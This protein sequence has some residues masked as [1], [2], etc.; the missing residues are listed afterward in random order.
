MTAYCEA[1]DILL[2]VLG[3][4]EKV[5][6]TREEA[7]A[8]LERYG[9]NE[10]AGRKPPS[11]F[12]RVLAQ[13][14][15]PMIL[16][17]LG[18][19]GLSLWAG[20]G[21]DWLD[22]AIILFI[23]VVNAAISI[24]Q[25]DHAQKALDELKRMAAPTALVRRA[26]ELCRVEA[27][28]LVPG[29]VVYLEAGDQVSADGRLL[30]ASGL[31][32]DESAMTGESVSVDKEPREGLSPDTPLAERRNMVLSGT[33]VTAGKGTYVVTATGMDTEMGRIAGLLTEAGG[34]ETPLQRRMGEI[35]KALSFLCLCVCAVMFGIGLLQGR[36]LMEMFL[37]AVSLAVAAIPEGLSAVV[38]IVLALGVQR[39]ARRGAIITKLAAV[40]TLGCAQVICSDKTGT[41]TRNRMEVTRL[42]SVSPAGQ[43]PALTAFAL[44][45]DAQL[46]P[47]GYLGDP[48]EGAL[49]VKAKEAGLSQRTLEETLPR[50]AE[51][52]FDST[53]KRMSTVH[54]DGGGWT[55]F[56][57]G[58]PEGVLE[59]CDKVL[60]AAGA[61]PL[62]PALRREIGRQSAQMGRDALRVLAAAR[63][64]LS[65][66]PAPNAVQGLERGL[67]FL[68]LAGLMDPP[69][70]EA[71]EA[72]AQ[73]HRA[74]IRPVMITGDHKAT[75]VAIAKELDILREGDG[76]VTGE[77][78]DFMTQ[79]M[80]EEE[81]ERIAVYARVTPEHKT[82]IVKA[83]QR[84]GRVVAM[85]GDG[86]NDAPAL[87][88][89]D[90][91]CAMGRGGTQVARSASHLIL[92][93]D[94]FATIVTAVDEGRGIYAN[95]K[96]AVHYLLSC[97]MGEILTLLVATALNFSPMPLSPV[98]LLWLN[99]VT[100]TLPALAL[101]MEPAEPGLMD[102][103]PRGGQE[104][105]F[106][107]AFTWRVLWQGA[108]V[109]GLTLG[110][111]ALGLL[112]GDPAAANTMAFATLTL[113]QLFHAFNARSETAS[114]FALGLTSN[115]AMNKAF[116]AGLAL[117]LAVLLL[118]PLRGVFGTAA[119]TPAQWMAVLGLA[120]SPIAV[121][122]VTKA[123]GKKR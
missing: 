7:R 106:T 77:E 86:V 69:R 90:I 98:Q 54:R 22:S 51:A 85:T 12:R 32:L 67:T 49:L 44:C 13:L 10:L 17:L 70:R 26:G 88:Q 110:A 118:P 42:W 104:G 76:A 65:A 84:G 31:R 89:A 102:A 43:M 35:S 115:R 117:Q 108:M 74:G 68:G 111:Y 100:D 57:K 8:R 91:G 47:E 37:T 14:K 48:T 11:L 36:A 72:V 64:E 82:R 120:A 79:E 9:P 25:E 103:P 52:P 59:R 16:V 66:K 119:L 93:D 33:L 92:T 95:I 24:S 62:T 50:V 60:T 114:L 97:N 87:K 61:V 2:T 1:K 34:R 105:L 46:T 55:L 107:P 53:R 30:W 23:V 63:R 75:A 27:R 123:A 40:E 41:L 80:L 113:S 122:E 58:A 116:L 73:C 20:G 5:G 28:E 6:L 112:A 109:A 15:D 81:A 56:V 29:D 99:L 3:S 18:A 39:L 45:N 19:A 78:L 96:K 94:N 101:G 71:K 4:D 121:C 38:T 83:L 21:R